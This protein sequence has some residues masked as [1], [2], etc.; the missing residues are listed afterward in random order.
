MK[1]GGV[2]KFLDKVIVRY[3][4]GGISTSHTWQ[5]PLMY[6]NQRKMFFYYQFDYL[7]KLEKDKIIEKLL[8]HEIDIYT[9]LYNDARNARNSKSYKIGSLLL[10]PYKKLSNIFHYIRNL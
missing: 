6:E 8:Q 2:F 9:R 7:Y 5:T 4:I 1:K 10:I 3:R